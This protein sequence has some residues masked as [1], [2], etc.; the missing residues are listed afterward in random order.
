MNGVAAAGQGKSPTIKPLMKILQQALE[1]NPT[2]A[3][4]TATDSF[5]T[6]QSTTTAAAIDKVRATG[7]YL[8]LY[9]DDAGRCVSVPFAQGGKTDRGEHVD[10]SYFL[11]AAH[12]DEFS[13]QT[14]RDR[15]KLFKK[16]AIHPSA[17]VPVPEQLCL[18][19]TNILVMWLM[20]ELYFGKY[21]SQM[22]MSRPIGLVQRVL[23]SFSTKVK[24]NNVKWDMFLEKV[25]SPVMLD[26][27]VLVLKTFGPKAPG[28]LQC[29]SLTPA[30]TRVAADIEETLALFAQRRRHGN[31]MRDAMPKSFYWFGTALMGN[32]VVS[33]CMPASIARKDH[34]VPAAHIPDD[35]Y[36]AC[37]N[38]LHRRYLCGQNVVACAAK[39]ELWLG[40]DAEE[41]PH[42]DALHELTLRAL[43]LHAG[44]T[45][46]IASLLLC[47]VDSKRTMELGTAEE[48][49]A[50]TAKLQ[51]ILRVIADLGLGEP[52]LSAETGQ[53]DGVRKYA[54]QSLPSQARGW[55]IANRVSL[56][57][58][59]TPSEAPVPAP[60]TGPDISG[61]ATPEL[62]PALD[63]AGL[64]WGCPGPPFGFPGPCRASLGCRCDWLG[65]ICSGVS[66]WSSGRSLGGRCSFCGVS[67]AFRGAHQ[68]LYGV[69]EFRS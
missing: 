12:G 34:V 40:I 54:L 18:N 9:S 1:E 47:D 46:T 2:L 39:E 22:A 5:H 20:Q 10:L 55:L 14:C 6:C 3:P 60:G 58:F 36:V 27:F 69:K 31:T 48:Q 45:I 50:C 37:V 30:Q 63:S 24:E 4:G 17:P 33:T 43:R 16:K 66:L 7:A 38:F 19:P 44:A 42:V 59:G 25:V 56:A 62:G 51:S 29:L 32:W 11:D 67:W 68:S 8:L 57:L 35:Q 13:H 21:W 49:G 28:E 26:F 41:P 61:R 15:D 53:L 65:G 23:F 52:M 64:F